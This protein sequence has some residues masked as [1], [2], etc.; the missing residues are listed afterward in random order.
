[1]T[2]RTLDDGDH[3][4]SRY[5]CQ[6]CGEPFPIGESAKVCAHCGAEVRVVGKSEI[7]DTRPASCDARG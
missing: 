5:V 4:E 3:L 6:E 1:M 2:D 7:I